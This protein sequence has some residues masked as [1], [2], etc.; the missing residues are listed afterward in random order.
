MDYNAT[1]P[2]D[3]RVLEAIM[4]YLTEHFGNTASRSHAYGWKAAEA[5]DTARQQLADFLG[6][7]KKEIILKKGSLI[8]DTAVKI[9]KDNE[10]IEELDLGDIK[11]EDLRGSNKT[12]I[13]KN[14]IQ[15]LQTKYNIPN[16][17]MREIIEFQKMK[18]VMVEQTL[19]PGVYTDYKG[20][21]RP[22]PPRKRNEQ[23]MMESILKPTIH[24]GKSKSHDSQ[25]EHY[26]A[27][28]N[29]YFHIII[30]IIY[31][32]RNYKIIFINTNII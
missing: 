25:R 12:N 16:E 10:I 14:I 6:C 28:L 18:S 31:T 5:V 30:E 32:S 3:K 22:A 15:K 23:A 21:V 26:E 19:D 11:I 20:N 8:D 2:L 9:I 1:T 7:T 4:P 17:K 13:I 27:L 29:R 24:T